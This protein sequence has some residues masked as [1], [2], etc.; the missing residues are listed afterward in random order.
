MYETDHEFKM[1]YVTT[2]SNFIKYEFLNLRQVKRGWVL[3]SV[4]PNVAFPRI[5]QTCL[6]SKLQIP[7]M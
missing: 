7:N 4:S 6:D 5:L 2:K 1:S 3:V